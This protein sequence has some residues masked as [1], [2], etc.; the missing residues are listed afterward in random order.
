MHD[1]PLNSFGSMKT[2]EEATAMLR[3]TLHHNKSHEEELHELGHLLEHLGFEFAARE[4]HNSIEDSRFA[5]EHIERAL[6]FML[7]DMG[8]RYSPRG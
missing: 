1:T 2:L 8:D 3:Y 5:S 7:D 4:V 6:N